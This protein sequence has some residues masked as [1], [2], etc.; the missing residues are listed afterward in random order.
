MEIEEEFTISGKKCKLPVLHRGTVLLGCLN[1][2]SE[3]R[4]CYDGKK[5]DECGAPPSPPP[6]PI[7]PIQDDLST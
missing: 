7:E 2:T 6:P 3:M 4:V 1:L 5:W